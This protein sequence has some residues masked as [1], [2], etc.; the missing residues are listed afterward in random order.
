MVD[1]S[2]TI[3]A[4]DGW[5]LVVQH[6]RLGDLDEARALQAKV[7]HAC[8]AR[9]SR[10]VLFDNR[11]TE[12]PADDVRD[13]MFEWAVTELERAAL[14][15]RSDLKRVRANMDALSRRGRVRA[16]VVEHEAIA[17]LLR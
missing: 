14:L 16:F 9:G 3:E 7:L 5:L 10:R 13:A 6:G 15:L 17:W 8:D 12:P 1:A 11:D 4:R 2:A